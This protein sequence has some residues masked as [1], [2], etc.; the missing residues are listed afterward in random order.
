MLTIWCDEQVEASSTDGEGRR[1]FAFAKLEEML[2]GQ[3]SALEM[4][5]DALSLSIVEQDGSRWVKPGHFNVSVRAAGLELPVLA[6][7]L[8][9]TGQPALV[10][11]RPV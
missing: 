2:V 11:D 9:L 10:I 6:A 4:P 1:L 5:L 3:S 8:E 7:T